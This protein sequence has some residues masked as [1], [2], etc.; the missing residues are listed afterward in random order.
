MMP[1]TLIIEDDESIALLIGRTIA[2]MGG[3]TAIAKSKSEALT[4]LSQHAI[5]LILLDLGLPDGDGKELIKMLRP[6]NTT[7]IIV[8]SARS[9]E[10]EIVTSLDWGADD[11]VTK[12]FSIHEL[13][14]RVR[15]VQRRLVAP[16]AIEKLSYCNA[17]SLD[18]ESHTAFLHSEPLKLTPTEFSLLAYLM[19]HPNRVLTHAQLLREV[20]GIGYQQEMQYL[21][22]YINILRKKIEPNPTQP[23]YIRTEMGIGYRFYCHF[24]K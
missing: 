1:T 13:M 15:S 6:T 3:S 14:A 4:L 18:H 16:V 20:W 9:D 10:K 19:L 23:H 2:S 5:G 22:T 24:E 7:P 17:L 11:Y 12:P 21:R 8:I